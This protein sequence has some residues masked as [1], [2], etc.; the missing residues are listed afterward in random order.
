MISV[1]K[2]LSAHLGDRA[3]HKSTHLQG[4]EQG[5][6]QMQGPMVSQIDIKMGGQRVVLCV[7]NGSWM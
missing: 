6:S 2:S 4:E 7:G 3:W 1:L 5:P